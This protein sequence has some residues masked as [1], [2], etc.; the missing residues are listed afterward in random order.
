MSDAILRNRAP[1]IFSKRAVGDLSTFA[2]E[3]ITA[4]SNLIDA[5]D[6]ILDNHNTGARSYDRD[7]DKAGA[8]VQFAVL[9]N[10]TALTAHD[11]FVV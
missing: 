7:G 5:D 9:D 3:D 10:R 11:F 8:A 1:G 6:G 4:G 2:F